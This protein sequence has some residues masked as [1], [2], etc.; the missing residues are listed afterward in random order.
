M[1]KKIKS[2]SQEASKYKDFVNCHEAKYDVTK[3]IQQ[4]NLN[5]MFLLL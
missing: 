1:N 2:V 3:D 4:L 5:F